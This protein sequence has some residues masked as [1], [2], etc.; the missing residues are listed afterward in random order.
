MVIWLIGLSGSGKTTL[1][2][3]LKEHCDRLGQKSFII[4]GNLVRDFFDNDLG[5]SK[6]DRV[7]NIKRIMLSA[8]TLSQNG[9]IVI[10]CNISPFEELREFARKKIKDYTEIYL[11][12][13]VE[14]CM[15]NDVIKMYQGNI[16]KT[17]IVGIDLGFDEPKNSDLTV[18]TGEETV[19]ES[20]QKIVN[21]LTNR[22]Q[23]EF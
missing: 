16:G 4:D 21:Y 17:E 20:F 8:H 7:A 1:G 2:N 3:K 23:M 9:I 12:R 13:D 19:E 14:A 5:Y 11:K 22:Y 18:H 15:R 10:V 6:E